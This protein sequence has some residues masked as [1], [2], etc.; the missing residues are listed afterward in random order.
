MGIEERKTTVTKI[1]E[2]SPP[3][4]PADTAS[5][6]VK[7]ETKVDAEIES[8]SQGT[9][10]AAVDT[11]AKSDTTK[12]NIEDAKVEE[13]ATKST[14]I[15]TP[16]PSTSPQPTSNLVQIQPVESPLNKISLPDVESFDVGL[17]PL[18]II[19]VSL[20]LALGVYLKQPDSNE[21]QQTKDEGDKKNLL[22]QI[23]DA[24]IAGI[25]SLALW[26]GGFW[27]ASFFAGLFSYHQVTGNWPDFTNPDEL[28]QLSLNA[29]LFVNVARLAA[30][31]RI[32]L[33][34]ASVP[35]VEENI[36][37][38]FNNDEA[39]EGV[40]NGGYNSADIES[41]QVMLTQ[42]PENLQSTQSL[43]AGI[44]PALLQKK[45]KSKYVP[46]DNTGNIEDY[47]EPGKVDED[48]S[49]SIKGYLDEL[50]DTGAVA[51][52]GEVQI[53]VNYLDSLSCNFVLPNEN[54]RGAAFTNYL[55]ALSTGF[56]PPPSSANAVKTYLDE[57][58]NDADQIEYDTR[59]NEVEGRLRQLE[60]SFNTLP[61]NIAERIV[62][63]QNEKIE[64][65][66]EKIRKVLLD[67]KSLEGKEGEG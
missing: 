2:S 39:V 12:S 30:P 50:S 48:C 26:E 64:K 34:L 40:E 25:I 17:L 56:V 54:T 11:S 46:G 14:T 6:L 18:V 37:S 31:L 45:E 43:N 35:W 13:D 42:S 20:S 65:E 4:T 23:K 29:F 22:E 41:E 15:G 36:L 10:E 52:D 24:G 7:E 53:I 27:L 33:A 59:V 38:R 28:K 8:T 21:Q 63:A 55:D 61:D 67:G 51:T 5:S 44:D 49:E 62:N 19:G 3:P 9:K 47:C 58:S 1:I 60:G 66:M 16:T 57:L 32:G